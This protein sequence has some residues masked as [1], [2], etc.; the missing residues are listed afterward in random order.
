M[1]VTVIICVLPVCEYSLETVFRLHEQLEGE[2]Q[3]GRV[4]LLWRL[5]H[6]RDVE[7]LFDQLV[8]HGIIATSDFR[9]ANH[10]VL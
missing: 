8:G 7:L 10:L 2:S 5:P 4:D 6:F 9:H 1:L 3:T